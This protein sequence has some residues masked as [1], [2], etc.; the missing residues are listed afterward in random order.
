MSSTREPTR[1]R[2]TAIPEPVAEPLALRVE[3]SSIV[4][5]GAPGASVSTVLRGLAPGVSVEIVPEGVL[6]GLGD[7]EAPGEGGSAGSRPQSSFHQGPLGELVAETY[8]SLARTSLWWISPSWGKDQRELSLE[9][10]LLLAVQGGTDGEGADDAA[11]VEGSEKGLCSAASASPTAPPI[12]LALV[13][14]LPLD[15]TFKATLLGSAEALEA[16]GV[17]GAGRS[18]VGGERNGGGKMQPPP[19]WLRAESGSPAVTASS[20]PRAV[21]LVAARGASPAAVAEAAVVRAAQLSGAGRG[22]RHKAV[23][24]A[25][26]VFGWCTWNAA[27]SA[28]DADVVFEGVR[29]LAAGGMPP[30][31]VI[32]D[33]GWQQTRLDAPFPAARKEKEKKQTERGTT[34]PKAAKKAFEWPFAGDA[35]GARGGEKR[36][37][38]RRKGVEGEEEG[39]GGGERA[40]EG[41]AKQGPPTET[42]GL[43]AELEAPSSEDASPFDDASPAP[44]AER[45]WAPLPAAASTAA[46]RDAASAAAR[47][48]LL[49]SAHPPPS[50]LPHPIDPPA[51]APAKSGTARAVDAAIGALLRAGR[52]RHGFRARLA[53]H[54][55]RLPPVWKHVGLSFDRNIDHA[56]RLVAPSPN[57]KFSADPARRAAL[58]K[59]TPDAAMASAG[60]DFAALSAA[61]REGFGVRHLFAWHAAMGYWAGVAASG[62]ARRHLGPLVLRSFR[63]PEGIAELDPGEA[64]IPPSLGGIRLP[65]EIELLHERMHATLQ[66]QGITGVKIDVQSTVGALGGGV[67]VLDGS[68]EE[69][70]GH[71]SRD[72]RG[73]GAAHCGAAELGGYVAPIK[74]RHRPEGAHGGA[75]R[76]LEKEPEEGKTES[77]KR[78][79]RGNEGSQGDEQGTPASPRQARPSSPS[80]RPSEFSPSPSP[81]AS[82]LSPGG[83]ALTARFQASIESSVAR[84]FGS[85]NVI[86]CMC[87]SVENLFN[88]SQS[89]WARASDDFYPNSPASQTVHVA[90]CSFNSLLIGALAVP[91]YDMFFSKHPAAPL[92]AAA[93]A[94]SGG[95]VYVSDAIGAHDFAVLARVAFPDGTALRAL[96]AGVPAPRVTFVDVMRDQT[97]AHVVVNANALSGV[98]LVANLQGAAYDRTTCEYAMLPRK[99]NAITLA[100]A[101]AKALG[102]GEN[103]SDEQGGRGSQGEGRAERGG[104]ERRLE[105]AI[106]AELQDPSKLEIAESVLAD[107]VGASADGAGSLLEAVEALRDDVID[108]IVAPKDVPGLEEALLEMV[109]PTTLVT[110]PAPSPR[111]AP[112]SAPSASSS[113]SSASSSASSW[114]AV[115]ATIGSDAGEAGAIPAAPAASVAPPVAL[116]R[117]SLTPSISGPLPLS[118]LPP[119]SPAPSFVAYRESTQSM[120]LLASADEGLTLS[121]APAQWDLVT[122]VP[123]AHV[124]GGRLFAPVGCPALYNL[125]GAVLGVEWDAED[126]EEGEKDG[127][128]SAGRGKEE[129]A[130]QRVGGAQ[131]PEGF[132][133]ASVAPAPPPGASATAL[134]RGGGRALLFAHPI[135]T[136]VLLAA[137]S[138][139]DF[140]PPPAHAFEPT[141]FAYESATGALKLVL[142][143]IGAEDRA[144]VRVEWD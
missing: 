49:S 142:P 108:A 117:P 124:R 1:R 95:P 45:T 136:R 15:G 71:E 63:P 65:L 28:V 113:A 38:T 14:L 3:G 9:T 42:Q 72:G 115:P 39:E 4:V 59:G 5:D 11:S 64:S 114:V 139:P 77:G 48:L 67:V 94:V 122:F 101:R 17:W 79:E 133:K 135:P 83:P 129:E 87:H 51:P 60:G 26:D 81:L 53:R 57:G 12:V 109:S 58:R 46:S 111:D 74:H 54:L 62:D 99:K 130:A 100:T 98:A 93:R 143:G 13:P 52:R 73:G 47:R 44:S 112:A 70:G 68:D 97:T 78:D 23:P 80:S 35:R 127:A 88:L 137:R 120:T 138:A 123:V 103:E 18:G 6:L 91:D 89:N 20:V 8:L 90:H 141:A 132:D 66:A 41:G 116:G 128:Q 85:G 126:E 16:G 110:S 82:A 56:R 25:C 43:E 118:P 69:A 92:H 131:P 84:H 121:L 86:N 50:S 10:Q 24:E 37:D 31:L 21:L 119:S 30:R 102:S 22:R 55:L 105:A 36:R 32:V 29:A 104:V 134:F 125:G 107:D 2:L 106:Q 140:A 144:D 19:L 40:A 33:D 96:R 34:E 7:G 27:Y 76:K 61:L 75:H